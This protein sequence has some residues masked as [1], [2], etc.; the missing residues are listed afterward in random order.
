M[1][2][3]CDRELELLAKNPDV[4]P[5]RFAEWFM[6]NRHVWVAFCQEAFKVRARGHKHYSARTIVHVLRHHSAVSECSDAGWKIDNDHSPYLARLFD[7]RYPSCAGMWEYRRV[8]SAARE[9]ADA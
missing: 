6:A 3:A 5:L 9:K 7:L 4:F 2:G 1:P 8:K